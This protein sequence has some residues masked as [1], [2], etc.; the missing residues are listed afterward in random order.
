MFVLLSPIVRFG[1]YSVS[2]VVCVSG[3]FRGGLTAQAR[4]K[5]AFLYSVWLQ[6]QMW[7]TILL[8]GTWAHVAQT[9]KHKV[10]AL[11]C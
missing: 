1:T 10:H 2:S 6:P 11:W 3:A 5:L 9:L 8:G 7:Y 4:H